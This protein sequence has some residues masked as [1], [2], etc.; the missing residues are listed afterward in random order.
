MSEDVPNGGNRTQPYTSC[1]ASVG[2]W[3]VPLLLLKA[4]DVSS[5]YRGLHLYVTVT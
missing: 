2:P 5:A 3:K 1:I 4:G